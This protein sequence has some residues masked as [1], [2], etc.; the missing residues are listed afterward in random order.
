MNDIYADSV[1]ALDEALIDTRRYAL[2]PSP[3]QTFREWAADNIK[4]TTETTA[5]PGKFRPFIYQEG[6][7]D[8]FSDPTIQTISVVKPTQVGYTALLEFYIGYLLEHDPSSILFYL[9]T[10]DDVRRFHDDHFMPMVKSASSVNEIMR[11][12]GE[13]NIRRTTKGSRVS[14]LSAA[15]AKNF[16]SHRARCLMVDEISSDAYDPSG[17]IKE[18]KINAGMERTGSFPNRKNIIGG[19]PAIDGRCRIT[20][21]YLRGDQRQLYVPDPRTGEFVTMDFGGRETTHGLKWDGRDDT[22][23]RYRFPSGEEVG[24]RDFDRK[25]LPDTCWVPTAEGEKGHASFQFNALV[26]PMPGASWDTIVR[27]WLDAKDK[28][29]EDP[30]P[31]KSFYNTV[32]GKAFEDYENKAGR[33]SVHELQDLQE[34]YSS[35]VPP[36]VNFLTAYADVQSGD[37]GWFAVKVVG[38][39]YNEKAH[40][41]GFWILKDKPLSGTEAWDELNTFL[42]QGF[43]TFEGRKMYIQGACIDSG[44]HYT[45][46]V[47]DFTYKN[48][49]RRFYA[50]K[51]K[52]NAKGKR[53]NQIWPKDISMTPKGE[54]FLV[55]VDIAKDVTFRRLHGEPSALNSI[56][57]PLEELEGS[58]PIDVRYF[59]NLTKEKKERVPGGSG[60]YWTKASGQENWDCLV[61]NLVCLHALRSLPGGDN[62]TRLT[63]KAPKE[64]QEAVRKRANSGVP[65]KPEPVSKPKPK[66]RPKYGRV[67]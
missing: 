40:V 37:D 52:S 54:V 34:T 29:R 17:K 46:E 6:I 8:A 67:H 66:R 59:E 20:S 28:V 38:W 7:M 43:E 49:E 53:S 47:Y 22:S 56:S 9:P 12:D 21:W 26:S 63:G 42:R 10:D 32:L 50:V 24:E 2:A 5:R 51:G 25:I 57:F 16:Q 36:G 62:F 65:V 31:M 61:G 23:V 39:G 48:K 35:T 58:E 55:D 4:L 33:R 44:G 45:Q 1:N 18:D 14:F 11:W 19:T 13:W 64:L 30:A 27:K 3:H 15:V 41:I 60:Y